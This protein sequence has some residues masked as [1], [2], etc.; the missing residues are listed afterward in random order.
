MNLNS[1]PVPENNPEQDING[2]IQNDE[3]DKVSSAYIAKESKL[4]VDSC[5]SQ[6][7]KKDKI[8]VI[9]F[10]STVTNIWNTEISKEL[11]SFRLE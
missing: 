3:N 4:F 2:K 9:T 5:F 8:T 10:G 11:F 1:I 6:F 7:S